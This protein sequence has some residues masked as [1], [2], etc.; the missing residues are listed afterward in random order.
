MNV[1]KNKKKAS[2]LFS[3]LSIFFQ[4]V[5]EA[6]VKRK[7]P[8]IKF[9]FLFIIVIFLLVGGVIYYRVYAKR[10]VLQPIQA[11]PK[12]S[13]EIPINKTLKFPAIISDGTYQ[14]EISLTMVSAEKTNEVLVQNNPVRAREG[15]FFLIV[16]L[17][18]ANESTEK[19]GFI[20]SDIIRL[21]TGENGKRLAPDLHNQQVLIAPVSVK[22]DRVG[23][24][25]TGS[26][27]MPL[28]LDLGEFNKSQEV[29]ERVELNF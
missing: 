9:R 27:N 18:L 3:L 21:A 13:Q 25:V 22:S 12:F 7:F 19:L 15:R 4:K 10:K 23:F 17:E 29:I 1:E 2:R 14:G 24:V 26:E 5:R 20:S 11:N 16:N 8:K 28:A 6:L